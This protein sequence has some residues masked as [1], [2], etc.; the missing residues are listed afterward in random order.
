VHKL[1]HCRF[2]W[3]TDR[4]DFTGFVSPHESRLVVEDCAFE[5]MRSNAFDGVQAEVEIRRCLF[6]ET[7]EAVHCTRSTVAI[8]E[9]T[10]RRMIGDKDAIDFDYDGERPSR[11]ERCRI[12]GSMDDGVDLADSTCALIG[13]YITDVWDKAL[14]FEG[15]GTMGHQTIRGN[16]IVRSGSAIALKSGAYCEDG[17]HNTIVGNIE[18]IGVYA[19]T[20]GAPGAHGVFDHTISWHNKENVRVDTA[21]TLSITDSAIGG[22][23]VWPGAGNIREDPAFVDEWGDVFY[24]APG[25]PCILGGGA[26]MG[27][28]PPAAEIFVR[29]DANA[30]RRIDLSDAIFTLMYLFAGRTDIPCFDALDENDDGSITIADPIYLLAYLYASGAAPP[31]PFPALGEDPTEDPMTCASPGPRR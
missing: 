30:D 12:Q 1:R 7:Y 23:T 22:D 20:P 18:G 4:D 9:C 2:R 31:P 24:L 25:S 14:S 28:L 19:K 15:D 17:S 29:G 10:F 13:N 8:E 3:G 6:L 5:Y 16:V 26:Y 21:S 11:I 27:A